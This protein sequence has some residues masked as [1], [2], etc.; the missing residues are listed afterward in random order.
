MYTNSITGKLK[1]LFARLSPVVLT[2]KN[3]GF[4]PRPFEHG[5]QAVLALFLIDVLHTSQPVELGLENT[6]QHVGFPA[7]FVLIEI[8]Q[9][10][11]PSHL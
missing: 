6:R 2:V 9:D 5:W 3:G 4:R 1:G 8:H 11:R 10:P 7:L